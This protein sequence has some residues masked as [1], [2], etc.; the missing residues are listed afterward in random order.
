M[1]KPSCETCRF[2]DYL[3]DFALATGEAVLYGNCRRRSPILCPPVAE[4]L[5]LDSWQGF[6]PETVGDD[7]CGEYQAKEGE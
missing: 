6:F 3:Y 7:W 1:D 2:W 4:D 5:G